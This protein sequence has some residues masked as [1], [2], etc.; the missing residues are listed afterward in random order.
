MWSKIFKGQV[1]FRRVNKFVSLYAEKSEPKD[2]ALITLEQCTLHFTYLK[3]AGII[4]SNSR[5]NAKLGNLVLLT[6]HSAFNF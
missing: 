1:H 6:V 4:R 5:I 2:A 3:R